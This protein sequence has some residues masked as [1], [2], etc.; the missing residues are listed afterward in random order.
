MPSALLPC[1]P[2]GMGLESKLAPGGLGILPFPAGYSLRPQQG[3]MLP[4]LLSRRSCLAWPPRAAM[5]AGS[6]PALPW[7]LG[8]GKG[9][10]EE[11]WAPSHLSP[12]SW[13]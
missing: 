6:Y 9:S 3:S 10:W 4:V 5:V 1:W 7:G 13:L 8:S 12:G 2:P 11:P